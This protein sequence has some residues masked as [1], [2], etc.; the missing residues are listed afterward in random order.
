[1]LV[2]NSNVLDQ[3]VFEKYLTKIS[4]CIT[5]EL[6]KEKGKRINTGT[7][8]QDVADPLIHSTTFHT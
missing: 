1:M 4:I 3:I 5:L 2:L 8:K 7:D 6:V